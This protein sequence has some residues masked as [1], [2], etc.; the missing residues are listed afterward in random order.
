[1]HQGSFLNFLIVPIRKKKNS[2]LSAHYS[3]ITFIL[4]A[5]QLS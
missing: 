2:P 4:L 1:M 5:D 3:I